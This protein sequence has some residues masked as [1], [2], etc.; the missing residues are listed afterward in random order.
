MT[1]TIT[2][3]TTGEFNCRLKI[4]LRID[5]F[6]KIKYYFNLHKISFTDEQISFQ[7]KEAQ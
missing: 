2:I 5:D 6:Q 3:Y 4:I 1:L 7:T